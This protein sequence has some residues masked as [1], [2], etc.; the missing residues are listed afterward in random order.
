MCARLWLGW[1][2]VYACLR[3]RAQARAGAGAG[4]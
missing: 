4:A 2:G 3:A 1:V